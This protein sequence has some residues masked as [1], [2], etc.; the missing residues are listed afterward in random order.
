M[1]LRNFDDSDLEAIHAMDQICFR[2]GIAYSREELDWY[3]HHPAVLTVIAEDDF[4]LAGFAM[5]EI[6]KK[7]KESS[8]HVITI[9]VH[10]RARRKGTGRMLMAAIE[11]WLRQHKIG[12][13]SL[14]VAVDDPGAL[15]FY[16]QID[17]MQAGKLQGYYMGTLDAYVLRKSLTDSVAAL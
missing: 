7:R 16:R 4:S 6:T 5:A 8:G 13:C 10:P 17:Y 14:E 1:Q 12:S 9:D 3:A 2:R 11:D 15:R